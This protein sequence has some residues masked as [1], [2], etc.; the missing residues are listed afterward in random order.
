[1]NELLNEM[2]L[3][4]GIARVGPE[5]YETKQLVVLSPDGRVID[6]L[7]GLEA[8]GLMVLNEAIRVIENE[9]WSD[10]HEVYQAID[11]IKKHFGIEQCETSL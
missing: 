11:L 5:G 9:Y 7:I 3:D 10:P 2:R 1:M 4:A 6:P 8:Y